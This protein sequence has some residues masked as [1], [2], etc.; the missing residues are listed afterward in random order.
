[1]RIKRFIASLIAAVAL[2]V[3]FVPGTAQARECL[4]VRGVICYDGKQCIT[5]PC[6][7]NP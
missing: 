6:Y 1:M 3:L 2:S 7:I 5:D 4:G